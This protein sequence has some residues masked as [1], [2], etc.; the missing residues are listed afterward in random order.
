MRIRGA[1]L[2]HQGRAG[3]APARH[4]PA[5]P[6]TVCGGTIRGVGFADSSL[7][8]CPTCRTGGKVLADR[9][10]SRLLE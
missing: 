3:P 1:G 10:V 9:R 4:G 5:R 7:P 2:T 6:C 8:Y